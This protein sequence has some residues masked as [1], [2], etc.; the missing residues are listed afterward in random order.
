MMP[1][2]KKPKPKKAYSRT[3]DKDTYLHPLR[4]RQDWK[5][6][7]R[8]EAEIRGIAVSTFIR[9]AIDE[10]INREQDIDAQK[11]LEYEQ[12]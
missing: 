4:C 10:K 2:K 8:Y 6:R 1:T 11:S 5:D 3:G 9:H 7:V 12:T